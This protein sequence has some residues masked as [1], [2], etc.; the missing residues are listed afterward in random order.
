M[1]SIAYGSPSPHLRKSL[2]QTLN[3]SKLNLAAPWMV[4]GDFN[5]V[6]ATDE[7]S[8]P[9]NIDSRRCTDFMDCITKLQLIDMGFTGP[10]F[11]WTHDSKSR[12][13]LPT[14]TIGHCVSV[15]YRPI[16]KI[17]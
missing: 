4:A 2:W 1:L 11:M 10:K 12:Y 6:V 15:R 8:L 13:W 14:R 16:H 7:T 9:E 3:L 17:R 5:L